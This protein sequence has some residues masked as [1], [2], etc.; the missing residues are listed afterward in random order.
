[1]HSSFIIQYLI[2]SKIS[3]YGRYR[4]F[5]IISQK[6]IG[7]Q[8]SVVSQANI[9]IGYPNLCARGCCLVR[10]LGGT[11][12]YYRLGRIFYVEVLFSTRFCSGK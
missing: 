4:I 8:P 7:E 3:V 5:P 1:M 9:N 2:L 11:P 10:F 6:C 12:V